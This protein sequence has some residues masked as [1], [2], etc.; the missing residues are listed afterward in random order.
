MLNRRTIV[1][2]LAAVLFC[3]TITNDALAAPFQAG[4]FI[5]WSQ[6]EW[7]TESTAAAQLLLNHFFD[8]Y[9][10]GVEIGISGAAGNSA[11]FTTPEAVFDY[12][13]A[14]GSCCA[15]LDND[16]SDPTSTSAGSFGGWVL[17]MQFNVDF[18]DAGLLSGT[19]GIPLADLILV[20]T[21]YPLF[22]GLTLRQYLAA[23]N[24]VLGGAPAPYPYDD[25][26]FLTDDI[27]RAFAGGTPTQFA[28]DHLLIAPA[29]V[30]EPATLALLGVGLVTGIARRF[31]VA[32]RS[33]HG[34]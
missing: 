28:Q 21:A 26:A 22:N 13:P 8:L 30:P 11:V 20:D 29:Q 31:K 9:P 17:A 5:T 12:L 32:G 33:P 4:D 34:R 16:Y 15:P 19:S 18:N 24:N 10:S 27:T 7:G 25:I 1:A 6:D 23:V 2:A 3:T 14:G